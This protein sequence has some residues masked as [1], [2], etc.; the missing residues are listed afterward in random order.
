MNMS[1]ISFDNIRQLWNIQLNLQKF[2]FRKSCYATRVLGLRIEESF[3]ITCY[4]I[5]GECLFV[6]TQNA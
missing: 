4:I 3:S 5:R 2:F 6:Y 1:Y